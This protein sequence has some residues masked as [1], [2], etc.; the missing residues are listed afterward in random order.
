M[1]RWRTFVL[2]AVVIGVL[3]LVWRY[4]QVLGIPGPSSDAADQTG[5]ID[6]THPIPPHIVWQ[7]VDRTPEGFKVEM[8]TDTS[9]IQIPAYNE[10]GGAEQVDMI[11]SYPDSEV[12]FSVAWADNPPVERVNGGSVE[13]TLDMARDD[14]LARTQ[15]TLVSETRGKVQG[16]PCRDFVGRNAEGGIFNARLILANTKLYML[17]TAFP[18]VSAR[19]DQ[20]VERFFDSF[21]LTGA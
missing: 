9:Q 16:Y 12:T 6:Q 5:T 19:R 15:T 14:A 3:F 8:P 10:R 1:K 13:Q 4:R 20:D 18:A 2:L 11:T 7:T 21:K 17:I